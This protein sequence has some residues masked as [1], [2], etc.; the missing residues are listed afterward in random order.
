[1]YLHDMIKDYLTDNLHIISAKYERPEFI[2]ED[3]E[4]GNEPLNRY[5][6]NI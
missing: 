2:M 3:V 6:E 4:I 1:M 5:T